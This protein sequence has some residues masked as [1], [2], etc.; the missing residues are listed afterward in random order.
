M[1]V[2]T[3]FALSLLFACSTRGPGWAES[4]LGKEGASSIKSE[5]SQFVS[6]P[7]TEAEP[8]CPAPQVVLDVYPDTGV[9]EFSG[10][11]ALLPGGTM[12]HAA[13]ACAR[14]PSKVATMN[15]SPT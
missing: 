12:V 7:G 4:A 6:A 13:A 8:V 5:A 11:S 1:R 14:R 10:V 9:I 15:C 3:A 2:A